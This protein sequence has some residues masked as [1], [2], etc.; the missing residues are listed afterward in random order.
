[1]G[2]EVW[3]AGGLQPVAEDIEAI[4]FVYL[5]GNGAVIATP[6]ADL[7]QIRSIEITMVARTSRGDKEY[8]NNTAYSNQSH[9]PDT[10][11]A[12]TTNII[13]RPAPGDNYRRRAL[14]T[15]VNCRN[16]GLQ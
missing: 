6:V 11:P 4:N 5:D 14:T 12:G 3:G 8:T 10:N 13:I 9:P 7:T 16:M 1:M 15:T 2:R